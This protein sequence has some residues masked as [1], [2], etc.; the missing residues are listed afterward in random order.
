MLT[1]MI[2]FCCRFQLCCCAR[3]EMAGMSKGE[4]SME[5]SSLDDWRLAEVFRE[6]RDD[7][8]FLNA[9]NEELKRRHSD[10]AVDLH[11]EVAKARLALARAATP[12]VATTGPQPP[13]V[14]REWDWLRA[15]LDRRSLTRPD[16]R[17][18][19]RYR[20]ADD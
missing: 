18:F 16:G 6:R 9:L 15:F 7:P 1:L 10:V 20:M 17:A 2:P 12:R 14:F 11:I 8:A 19:H 3:C 4:P 5:L 13:S